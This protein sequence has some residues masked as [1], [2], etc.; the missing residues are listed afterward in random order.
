MGEK[1]EDHI[2]ESLVNHN[3]NVR[4]YSE[5]QNR[6]TVLISKDLCDKSLILISENNVKVE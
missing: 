1:I 3:K 2:K 4:F 6:R 5:M